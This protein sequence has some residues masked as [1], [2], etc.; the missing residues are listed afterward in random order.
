[1]EC[2]RSVLGGV[3]QFGVGGECGGGKRFCLVYSSQAVGFLNLVS[4]FG[5]GFP[6]ISSVFSLLAGYTIG[7]FSC[8]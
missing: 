5:G 2:G 1:M 7:L 8:R 4:P 6:S 3:V